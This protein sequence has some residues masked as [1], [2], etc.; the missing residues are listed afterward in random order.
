MKNSTE[1]NLTHAE[2]KLLDQ[3]ENGTLAGSTAKIRKLI[4]L[5]LARHV[6]GMRRHLPVIHNIESS[7]EGARPSRTEVDSSHCG[8]YEIND[9]VE[10]TEAGKAYNDEL[11]AHYEE[12]DAS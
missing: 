3:A 10:L 2:E 9:K 8:L 7:Y 6:K 12:L 11:N 1:I 4:D 5:G